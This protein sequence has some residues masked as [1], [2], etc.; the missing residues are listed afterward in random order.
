MTSLW[1]AL[2]RLHSFWEAA[3]DSGVPERVSKAFSN[4]TQRAEHDL[5]VVRPLRF[6]PPEL[7]AQPEASPPKSPPTT[8]VVV[9][10]TPSALDQLTSR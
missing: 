2:D 10:A 3:P 7:P 5:K 4:W 6:D 1:A 9:E 8:I